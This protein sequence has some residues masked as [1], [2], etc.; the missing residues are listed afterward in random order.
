MPCSAPAGETDAAWTAAQAIVASVTNTRTNMNRCRI[1]MVEC[2]RLDQ[3]TTREF[4]AA[5]GDED[6]GATAV[7]SLP[8]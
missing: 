8:I 7:A 2:V 4:P 6:E 3:I 5:S 1:I